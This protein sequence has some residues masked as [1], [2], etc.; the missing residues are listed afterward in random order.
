MEKD[1][2]EQV[3]CESEV[4]GKFHRIVKLP[5]IVDKARRTPSEEI[6][7]DQS[8]GCADKR[9]ELSCESQHVGIEG[10]ILVENNDSKEQA[11]LSYST[12]TTSDPSNRCVQNQLES[13]TE[14]VT[15]RLGDLVSREVEQQLAPHEQQLERSSRYS[16]RTS[17]FRDL[18]KRKADQISKD[19]NRQ[20]FCSI[21]HQ[22][23]LSCGSI[24]ETDRQD[25]GNSRRSE[26][27]T[28]CISHPRQA[29]RDPGFAIQLGNF[30]RLLNSSRYPNGS[31]IRTPSPSIDRHVCKQNEQQ[32]Q[33]I[34][35]TCTGQLGN[36]TG[37]F[38][39][40]V[41]GRGTLSTPTNPN[42]TSNTQQSEIGSSSSCDSGSKLAI[43]TL[44]AQP[45][46]ASS[47]VCECG[48]KRGRF[49]ARRTDAKSEKTPSTGR[50]TCSAARGEKGEQLF[51]WILSR[52]QFISEATDK[53][54]EGWHSIWRRHRQR[55]GEFEE[56]WMKQG[57]SW[58][59][60]MTVKDPEVVISN[61]LAQQDRSKSSDANTNACRTAIGMLFRIQ[62]FQ[63]KEING[64]ALKQMMKKHQYA[65]RKKRKEE[66]IYKL[67]ILL[68]YIQSKFEYIEQ[69]SEQEHM[70]C[71][72]SSIMA[73][74]TLRLTEIHRASAT[75]NEDDS[76]QL[77][78]TVQKGDDYDLTVTFRPVSN[79]QICP[80]AWLTSMF[81]RMSTD[82][83]T[84]PLWWRESRKKIASYEYLSKAV[85][86]VMKGAGVQDKNSVTSIRKSSIT[87]SIDQGASQQE[88]DRASRQKE[89]AG[90]MAV[91]Y[92]MNLNDKLRERL[93][94]F[95]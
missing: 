79:R 41:V 1:C 2:A 22:Q 65:T 6:E 14:I 80:T 73:F 63:E 50:N 86:M 39:T 87:K 36:E 62:G 53:V 54:I 20:Q 59:D 13:Y 43:S 5:E 70:G 29:K 64:F 11:N 81:A 44:V 10:D 25:T 95:E 76:W 15:P 4:P 71:V 93:T 49:E 26:P 55:I 57:K 8:L 69:L 33:E 61:F 16:L 34:H 32:V 85:H 74:A 30:R 45:N 58:E 92:D 48:K 89:G 47:E 66:P 24:S 3:V 83:Q 12:L 91:H 82:D 7:Q 35:D 88:L 60:L 37:L 27:V 75:R 21:Q 52:R 67:D 77:D 38:I 84:K 94:N 51:K 56:F 42:D 9:M 46:R 78:T 68:R 19:R 18:L 17:A 23:G 40:P 90:T 31:S 28:S 72:I